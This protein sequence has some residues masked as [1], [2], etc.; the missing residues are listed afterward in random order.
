MGLP[1]PDLDDKKFDELIKEARSLITRY[2]PEWTDHNVH[3]PG[4]TF[5]ELFSWLAEMQIYQLNRLTDAQYLKFLKLAGLYPYTVKPAG[6]EITFENVTAEKIIGTGTELITETGQE[7]IVF[8]TEEE[9]TLIP[10]ALKSIK[11]VHGSQT[12]D[13][14]EA[15]SKDDI[16]FAVFGDKP[17]EGSELLLGFDDKLPAGGKIHLSFVLYEDDLPA[18]GS[19]GGEQQ[20]VLPSA[21]VAWEYLSGGIWNEVAVEK[22]TTLALMKSGRIVFDGPAFMD[23]RDGLFWIRCRLK[24]GAYEIAPLINRIMLNTILAVQVEA[25][26]DESYGAGSGFPGHKVLLKKIPVIKGSQTVYLENGSGGW[27]IWDEVGDFDSSDPD[28]LHYIFDHEKGEIIFGNGLN[29]RIPLESQSINV[30]YKT[31]LGLTGNIPEGWKFRV[32]KAGFEG[33]SGINLEAAAGGRTAETIEDAKARAKKDF[34]T[35]YRC[36]TS[37]DYELMALSTPGLRVARAKVIPDYHPGYPCIP[38]PGTVTVVAV[39][40]VREGATTPVPGEG[41]LLTILDHLNKHRLITTDVHVIGPEYVKVS[42]TAGIHIRKKS[43]PAEVQKRLM[44]ALETFLDPL[45]GGPDGKGWLFGR[46]VYISE[47]YQVIDKVEGVDYATGVSI[48]AEGYRREGDAIR[49][50]PVSLVFSG[51]HMIDI[52]PDVATTAGGSSKKTCDDDRIL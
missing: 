14:T 21:V 39:P 3:D 27:D 20:K 13:N 25:V 34:R 28:D 46:A 4:I 29:G 49:I 10:V 41:F 31:T 18:P 40:Y 22:D 16:S 50:S 17:A 45:K 15:N 47:I 43:S 36:I 38:I 12:V 51:E 30:S 11:T 42:V 23:E 19:H 6:V 35:P 2:A 24:E 32:N 44:K 5:V 7:K 33:I 37:T 26:K 48:S 1:V 8:M 9:F 52:N